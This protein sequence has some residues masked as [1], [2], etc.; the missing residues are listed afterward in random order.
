MEKLSHS[1]GDGSTMSRK[2]APHLIHA[3]AHAPKE[4]WYDNGS[5][6]GKKPPTKYHAGGMDDDHDHN[7]PLNQKIGSDSKPHP[8]QKTLIND[9]RKGSLPHKSGK[10]DHHSPKK[11]I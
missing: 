6:G 2:P 9:P 1:D 4:K 10:T 3:D 11:K 7:A 5:G 8:S